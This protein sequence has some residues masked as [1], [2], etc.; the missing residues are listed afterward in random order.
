MPFV[1]PHPS[2][3]FYLSFEDTT[4]GRSLSPSCQ[5]CI[6]PPEKRPPEPPGPPPLSKAHV[7]E[8]NP[9]VPATIMQLFT[10][11]EV[12]S[13][14]IRSGRENQGIS[15]DFTRNLPPRTY[16]SEGPEDR[17]SGQML[18]EHSPQPIGKSRT[19]PGQLGET[20]GYQG[21]GSLQFP[22]DQDLR[23]T[24][25][26][27]GM[28]S[29]TVATHG[30]LE[31]TSNSSHLYQEAKI[32]N[33]TDLGSGTAP[34]VNQTWVAPPQAFNKSFRAPTRATPRGGKGRGVPY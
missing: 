26:P 14:S 3:L 4:K 25:V 32:P 7:P 27:L 16:S 28:H 22:G 18:G 33:Y 19:F 30:Q 1:F 13:A 23:F 5:P 20:S 24:R 29:G 10:P 17:D 2:P 8:S 31:V 6:L 12:E 11:S 15:S 9:V 21:T 34:A